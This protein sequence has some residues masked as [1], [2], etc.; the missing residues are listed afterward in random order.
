M[1]LQTPERPALRVGRQEPSLVIAPPLYIPELSRQRADELIDLAA[2][3]GLYLDPWQE[4]AAEYATRVRDG[5]K[6]SATRVG[7]QANRQNGK[8][9]I[10]E[11]RQLGGLFLWDERVQIH[12]AHEFDT[13]QKH[14]QRI[15]VLI[16]STPILDAK[17]KRIRLADGE[18][19]IETMDGCVLQF[20]AR[21]LR[22]GRGLT[23]DV[24]YLD[25]A[26]ALKRAM[27]ASLLP[28]LS[29]RSIEGNV[30]VWYTSSA[31]LVDSEVYEDVREAA[32]K[33]LDPRLLWMEWAATK[34]D[35]ETGEVDPEDVDNWYDANPGLGIRIS[36][37][38]V[39][40]ELVS[41]GV[42]EF[43]RERLGVWAKVGGDT[44]IPRPQWDK[45]REHDLDKAK[46]QLGPVL[47]LALDV[48]PDR[49]SAT[50]FMARFRLD[51]RIHLEIVDRRD[52]VDWVPQALATLKDKLGPVGI[53]IDAAGGAS[54][55]IPE[56]RDFKVYVTRLSARDYAQACGRL[57]DLIMQDGIVHIGQEDL[58]EAILAGRR[59]ALGEGLWRWARKDVLT[60]I[61]PLCAATLAV[62]ILEKRGRR[63]L[64]ALGSDPSTSAKVTGSAGRK[65]RL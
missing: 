14:F 32:V 35:P 53:A 6:W 43:K 2:V 25:E 20:K 28:T 8:G 40:T 34:L 11:A 26:F 10:L 30:Q 52:D 38:F 36:E 12:T 33:G 22:S 3:A 44:V 39:R 23:G 15:R 46:R 4:I 24:I 54:V 17:V 9:S 65:L 1:S 21:A 64:R 49:S 58:D 5:G 13:A 60:D 62:Y 18:E 61:S 16:E 51:G 57:Y 48:P 19:S 37:D 29:A 50:I 7:V 45:Q 55:L 59:R 42:E 31:G 27:M 41:L 56:L 47:G 63:R